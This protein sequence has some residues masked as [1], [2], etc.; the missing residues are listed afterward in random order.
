MTTIKILDLVGSFAE[1]KDVARDLRTQKILPSM[2]KNENIIFDFGGVETTT[3]SFVHALIS[4][5][6]RTRG[7]D[8]FIG[9]TEFKNCNDSVKKIINIVVDYMQA[10]D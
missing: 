9:K 3:Q 10:P 4:D 8:Q 1:N 5:T 6:I 7:I 2:E